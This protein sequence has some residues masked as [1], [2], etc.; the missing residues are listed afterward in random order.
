MNARLKAFRAFSS[1]LFLASSVVPA[2]ALVSF[3]NLDLN[4]DDEILFTTEQ[5]IPG[6]PVYKTIVRANVKEDESDFSL[7]TCF[8]EKIEVTNEGKTLDI[9]NR[10]GQARYDF[11]TSTLSWISQTQQI[12][13]TFSRTQDAQKSPDGKWLCYIRKTGSAT[14]DL[15]LKNLATGSTTPIARNIRFSYEKVPV[16]WAPDSALLIYE[17][18]DSLYFVQPEDAFSKLLLPETIRKIGQGTINS[19]SWTNEKQFFYINGDLIYRI[20]ENG[21]YTRSLYSSLI[22][23]GSAAA[24]L[25]YQFNSDEDCFWASPRGNAIVLCQKK[26]LFTY[27]RISRTDF[28]FATPVFTVP[29]N[30]PK[31][32]LYDTEVLWT[33]LSFDGS[34][35]EKP[36]FW[37]SLISSTDGRL[38]SKVYKLDKTLQLITDVSGGIKPK[39]SPDALYMAFSSEK[40]LYVYNLRTCTL[41][42]TLKGERIYSFDWKDKTTLVVGGENTVRTFSVSGEKGSEKIL[43]LS[44]AEN[45]FWDAQGSKIVA[46]NYGRLF[47]FNPQRNTWSIAPEASQNLEHNIQNGRYRVFEGESFSHNFSNALYVRTLSGTPKNRII[48]GSDKAEDA[49]TKESKRVAIVFDALDN[50]SGIPDILKTLDDYSLKATF[51]IN[52]EFVR[53]YPSELKQ[54]IG[55]GHECAS[56]FYT[57]S[58]LTEQYGFVIDSDFIKRGLAREEDEFFDRTQSE[59]SLFWHAPF[60]KANDEMKAAAKEAGYTYIEAD[61]HGLDTMSFEECYKKKKQYY[62]AGEIIEEYT[63]NIHDT[64]VLAVS[65]GLSSG[66]RSDYLF[67]HLDLLIA[68]VLDK[69]YDIVTVKSLYSK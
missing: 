34:G 6:V 37:M 47:L 48:F 30:D 56:M 65:T 45:A 12:D 25:S 33:P 28:D 7:L 55:R 24:R 49:K 68:A 35:E 59:L 1:L 52:G 3:S 4:A 11:S 67:E 60:Y 26:R 10:F 54:I 32:T 14:G 23:I 58:D 57:A 41:K 50:A 15:V 27:A 9:R 64:A 51:F 43:F 62:S 63:K 40:N 17:H 5:N 19:I 53:R 38:L 18:D 42:A 2:K 46:K 36:I 21:L 29:F 16:K 20:S 31:G 22:G 13:S 8:P 69:G 44:S 39:V 61:Y 66:S